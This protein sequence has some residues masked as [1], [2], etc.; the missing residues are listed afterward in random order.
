MILWSNS[1][2][3]GNIIL[4]LEDHPTARIILVIELVSNRRVI[5]HLS[6]GELTPIT[7]TSYDPW[8]DP[9]SLPFF[10][11]FSPGPSSQGGSRVRPGEAPVDDFLEND[12]FNLTKMVG[13]PHLCS[14]VYIM[15][16]LYNFI[17]Y[18]CWLTLDDLICVSYLELVAWHIFLPRFGWPWG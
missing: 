15:V 12:V 9:P 17:G 16:T 5:Q 10:P 13:F 14:F 18:V 3:L 8:D 7:V 11:W 1:H 4:Y 6:V 2:I